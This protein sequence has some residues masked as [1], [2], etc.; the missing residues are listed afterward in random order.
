M[1]LG[2]LQFVYDSWTLSVH[3][4][5]LKILSGAPESMFMDNLYDPINQQMA[6][7]VLILGM[8]VILV[9]VQPEKMNKT[10]IPSLRKNIKKVQK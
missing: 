5:V 6:F 10:I 8:Y 4:M 3:P 2:Q 1:G 9:S 7:C